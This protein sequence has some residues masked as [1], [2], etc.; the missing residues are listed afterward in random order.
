MTAGDS[1]HSQPDAFK[2]TKLDNGIVGVL[3]TRREIATV[4]W[5]GF[6]YGQ[7]IKSN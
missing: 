1:F 7:L 4:G 3:G 2:N 5:Q 6:R